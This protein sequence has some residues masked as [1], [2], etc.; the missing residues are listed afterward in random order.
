MPNREDES[1]KNINDEL[2]YCSIHKRYYDVNYGCQLCLINIE[3]LFSINEADE[4]VELKDC[5]NCFKKSLFWVSDKNY[6]ECLNLKCKNTFT[7]KQLIEI[8]EL[9]ESEPKG[10]AWW[11]NEYF[12]PKTKKWKKPK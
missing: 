1:S 11:G 12:D 10:K 7:E 5:P 8:K 9:R 2:R 3:K 6:Y 4:H